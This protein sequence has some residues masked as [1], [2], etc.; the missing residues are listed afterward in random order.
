MHPRD[1]RVRS[2]FSLIIAGSAVGFRRLLQRRERGLVLAQLKERHPQMLTRA[3]R[4]CG[5]PQR[6][7]LFRQRSVAGRRSGVGVHCLR[8][9]SNQSQVRQ[10]LV[11]FARAGVVRGEL[12]QQ[13][14]TV[15]CPCIAL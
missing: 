4:L 12:L 1:Q 15:V 5:A 11:G 14:R 8:S 13:R 3:C 9:D 7:Q 10:R 2:P 6:L